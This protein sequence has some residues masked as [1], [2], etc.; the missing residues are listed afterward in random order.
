MGHSASRSNACAA[1]PLPSR[2]ARF[3]R[4]LRLRLHRRRSGSAGEDS[5]KPAIPA[6]EFAGIARIRIVKADMQF[7]DKFFACLSLGDRTYRTD[8]SDN[9][10]KPVWNSEKKVIV[11]T[12][13]PHIARI[14]VFEVCFPRAVMKP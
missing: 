8:T 5:G 4:R 9:T 7:K 6:D 1:D 14:S 12:N 11:E 3:R 10:H 2:S 13:G